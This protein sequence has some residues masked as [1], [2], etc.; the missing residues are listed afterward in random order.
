MTNTALHIANGKL[1]AGN[2]V[3][4]AF[5]LFVNLFKKPSPLL[6]LTLALVSTPI[7][8]D[9]VCT[10]SPELIGVRYEQQV[11][12]I[13]AGRK[14]LAVMELWRDG[15]RVMH[16]YPDRRLAEQWEQAESGALHLTIWHDEDKQGIE[17]MPEDLGS[18]AAPSQWAE[19]WQLVSEK[20]IQSLALNSANKADCEATLKAQQK[21]A[22]HQIILEWN[23]HLQLPS[24]FTVSTTA[25]VESWIA[26]EVINDP[27][28]IRRFFAQREA[29]KTTD[30]IDIGD[31]ESDPFLRKMIHLGF[32]SHGAS[33]FYDAD[34]HTL[35]NHSH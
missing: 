13:N 9:P 19:K 3:F 25:K 26:K 23:Q 15:N 31:N 5:L 6:M 4:P 30:Y 17:Y 35:K 12:D 16:V 18:R 1:K 24:R 22:T 33:G 32:V 21:T 20:L 29:Y 34:G 28:K 8:A 10:S 2:I 27:Q 11:K 7:K 14:T